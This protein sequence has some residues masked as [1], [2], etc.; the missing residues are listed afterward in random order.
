[1]VR[2]SNPVRVAKPTEVDQGEA[3]ATLP[4]AHPQPVA[5]ARDHEQQADVAER[6]DDNEP[7]LQHSG[8]CVTLGLGTV[9]RRT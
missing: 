8:S 2:N 5:I 4:A 6:D 3:R 1:M 7:A 9:L